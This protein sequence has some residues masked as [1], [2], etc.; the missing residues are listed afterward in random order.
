MGALSQAQ[1]SLWITKVREQSHVSTG[2]S[3]G[4]PVD[5]K[6]EREQSQG[7][8]EPSSN[9]PVDHKEEFVMKA[10]PESRAQK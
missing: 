3:S 9:E 10:E 2:T 6:D 8:I 4:E 7:S 5:H 1:T